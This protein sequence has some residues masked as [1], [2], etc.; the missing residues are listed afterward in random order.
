MDRS[1]K[2]RG[3]RLSSWR[4]SL[5]SSS[6]PTPQVSRFLSFHRIR[7]SLAGRLSMT[8]REVQVWFQNR[9]A[10]MNRL[11]A[12]GHPVPASNNPEKAA[13]LAG[14]QSVQASNSKSGPKF[15]KVVSPKDGKVAR[16]P[17]IHHQSPPSELVDSSSYH[18]FPHQI[19]GRTILQRQ[20]VHPLSNGDQRQCRF[21]RR[22]LSPYIIQTPTFG[23]RTKCDA[24]RNCM[25]FPHLDIC[26]FH[27]RPDW[28]RPFPHL[29]HN[30]NPIQLK[31]EGSVCHPYMRYS[32]L[33]TRGSGDLPPAMQ[34]L[35]VCLQL[36]RAV[37]DPPVLSSHQ[38]LLQ[39]PL[40]RTP[41]QQVTI[42][43]P[44]RTA[45]NPDLDPS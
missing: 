36:P 26:P 29:N 21:L 8:N 3:S 42:S 40:C 34:S 10:K 2:G 43:I 27:P 31:N 23:D 28:T 7:E 11:R 15:R 6:R 19:N 17:P 1:Q 16:P 37:I 20:S 22:L 33:L 30:R 5:S 24:R 32:L 4:S 44:H 35:L 25:I 45:L 38:P 41:L 13:A 9:R 12:Q 39:R 14:V 18:S